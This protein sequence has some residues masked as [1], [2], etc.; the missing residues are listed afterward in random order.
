[1]FFKYAG[2]WTLSRRWLKSLKVN[3]HDADGPFDRTKSTLHPSPLQQRADGRWPLNLP[4]HF[5]YSL[6]FFFF[7]LKRG[8]KIYKSFY[9]CCLRGWAHWLET[10]SMQ[11]QEEKCFINA[12]SWTIHLV[13][14]SLCTQ[15]PSLFWVSSLTKQSPAINWP[16]ESD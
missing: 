16:C 9:R 6:F 1:M 12:S 10:F 8:L 7:Y 14:N 4:F 3:R 5:F 13:C 11:Q 2:L 15:T